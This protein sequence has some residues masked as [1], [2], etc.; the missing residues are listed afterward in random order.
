[1]ELGG[2]LYILTMV[3]N[4]KKIHYPFNFRHP[5]IIPCLFWGGRNESGVCGGCAESDDPQIRPLTCM[6][7]DVIACYLTYEALS[8][9][10][11]LQVSTTSHFGVEIM[12]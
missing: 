5:P 12:I 9:L 1:L 11:K 3:C 2:G 8:N 4:R 7:S 10:S 6:L